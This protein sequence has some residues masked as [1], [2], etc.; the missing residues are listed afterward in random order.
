MDSF[1]VFKVVESADDGVD[2]TIIYCTL[3]TLG[4]RG[5][6]NSASINN[7]IDP[8]ARLMS[9]GVSGPYI[10][11]AD[12]L[13]EILNTWFRMQNT[14]PIDEFIKVMGI[15]NVY[16]TNGAQNKTQEHEAIVAA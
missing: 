6:I 15:T 5:V 2:A 3:N 9:L 14:M 12:G 8:V 1:T 10:E 16:Y 11:Y 13:Y 7:G 4:I